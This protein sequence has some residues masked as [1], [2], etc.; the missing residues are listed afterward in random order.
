[1]N[2]ELKLCVAGVRHNFKWVII[3]KDAPTLKATALINILVMYLIAVCIK[4]KSV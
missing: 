1:M 3:V 4:K 2:T